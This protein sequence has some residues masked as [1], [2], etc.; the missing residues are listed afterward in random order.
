VETVIPDFE[1]HCRCL[2][3]ELPERGSTIVRGWVQ[4]ALADLGFLSGVLLSSCRHLFY[5]YHEEPPSEHAARIT[6]TYKLTSVR[7]LR[8]AIQLETA[9][10][11]F[12]KVYSTMTIAKALALAVDEV[13]GSPISDGYR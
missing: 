13:R 8:E 9:A 4:P 10:S 6:D 3:G 1:V 12:R 11:S 5:L 7:G 2:L